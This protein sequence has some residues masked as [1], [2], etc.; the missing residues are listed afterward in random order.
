M[1]RDG[2][3]DDGL[4]DDTAGRRLSLRSHDVL[5]ALVL[6]ILA[7]GYIGMAVTGNGP[8]HE[9]AIK[10]KVIGVPTTVSSN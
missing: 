6:T 9:G 1:Q 4:I 5:L 3:R 10:T 7:I 2:H 8:R